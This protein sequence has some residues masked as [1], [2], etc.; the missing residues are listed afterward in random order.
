MYFIII[1]YVKYESLISNNFIAFEKDLDNLLSDLNCM[2]VKR[3]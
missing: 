2:Q 1:H 3:T